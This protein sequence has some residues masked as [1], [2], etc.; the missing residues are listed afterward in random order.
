MVRQFHV[1]QSQV[2]VLAR[3]AVGKDDGGVYRCEMESSVGELSKQ[4][5]TLYGQSHH[6]RSLTNRYS[7]KSQA[8]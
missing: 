6:T 8:S 2:L 1:V 3:G 4:D 7:G 5:V